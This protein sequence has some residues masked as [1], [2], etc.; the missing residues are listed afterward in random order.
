MNLTREI[1]AT[2]EI[3]N[4][5][6][7][8]DVGCGTGQT[9]AFL[10]THYKANVT[11]LDIN[12]IMV[13]KAQYRME[14]DQLGVEIIQ[15]SIEKCPIENEK[16]D[17]IISESVL[18]FVNATSAMDEIFRLLKKGGRFIA[19][20]LT[21]NHELD[22]PDKEEIKKFYGFDSFLAEEEWLSLLEKTGFKNIYVHKPQYSLQEN[23][24]ITEFRYSDSIEP[25]L[26]MVMM[27]HFINMYE[28]DGTIDYRI[29]S[30][31]KE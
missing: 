16:F 20:E 22:A 4:T 6:H 18:A 27:Q 7:I 10:A 23:N 8:L 2:E 19:N 14:Q 17:L 30:C 3:N 5:S 25:K 21:I 29:Y 28:Y 31:T 1:L 26:F 15:G 11:G 24:T 12:P 13:E 9:A